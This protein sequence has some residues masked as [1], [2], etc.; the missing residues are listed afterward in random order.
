MAKRVLHQFKLRELAAVDSPAQKGAVAV[1]LKMDR[2][3]EGYAKAAFDVALTELNLQQA[4]SDAVSET[5]TLND[6]L[7]ESI[8]EI[9]DNPDRYPDPRKAI[10]ESVQSYANAV[11]TMVQDVIAQ[12]EGKSLGKADK[13]ED[14]KQFP[15]SD[16]A[17][18]PDPEQPST[19][20][21]RLTAT[22]GGG[23]DGRIVGAA[24][25][26]LGPG[27]RGRKVQ[28][29]ESDLPKVKARVRQAWR[30]V[31][32][33]DAE[34][35][36]ILKSEGEDD[37]QKTV[38]QLQAELDTSRAYGELNDAGKAHYA[39]LDSRDKEAFLKL[40]A[41][42]RAAEMK[43][44]EDAD[45]VVY[46]ATDGTVYR[47]SHDPLLV[48]TAK[49]NDELRKANAEQ[50]A[51]LQNERL[52]KRA[53]EE[54]ANLPGEVGHKVALLKAVDNIPDEK[55]RD[56]VRAMLKAGNDAQAAAFSK[57]GVVGKPTASGE[58]DALTKKYMADHNVTDFAKAQNEVLR[59]PEGKAAY[60]AAQ[61]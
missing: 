11:S 1:L 26:A 43:K 60:E 57:V 24:V 51:L 9:V 47:K 28:I 37:M 20:K 29:P 30:K 12:L 32:G 49:D 33:S 42:D 13:T 31:H 22:P 15:A 3:D 52:S 41:T 2:S 53:G 7:R 36:A 17:Y 34:L 48:K 54:L 14:G 21:L 38:E 45:A 46:T 59:T 25:A 40:S 10:K 5:W 50:A 23:P 61:K 8:S 39:K 55:D 35:P 27:F 58:L 44:A 4:V 19:W 6:A 18:V 16:Y 56:A